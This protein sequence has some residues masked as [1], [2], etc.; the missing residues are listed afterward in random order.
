M[1]SDAHFMPKQF[2]FHIGFDLHNFFPSCK[3]VWVHYIMD[4]GIVKA[5]THQQKN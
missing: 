1:G 5:G 2:V 4:G 3:L